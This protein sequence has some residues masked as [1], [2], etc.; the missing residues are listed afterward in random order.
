M[1][2]ELYLS[3]LRATFFM[4]NIL[5]VF[6]FC[7]GYLQSALAQ[8]DTVFWFAAPHTWV[9]TAQN[10]HIPVQ[11]IVSNPNATAASVTVTMPANAGFMPII[12]TVPAGGV[13][14]VNL[15]PFNAQI[16]HDVPNTVLNRG[17]KVSSSLPVQVTYEVVSG[18]CE[19]NPEIFTLKGNSGLGQLFYIPFQQSWPNDNLYAPQPVAS[20]D[21]VA[22]EDSTLVD[23][24]PTTAL[25]GRAAGVTFQVLLNRGQSYSATAATH[26]AGQRPSGSRVTSN[27][28]ISITVKDDLVR[29][30]GGFCADLTGD[31]LVPVTGYSKEFVLIRG[32]LNIPDVIVIIPSVTGVPVLANG[33]SLGLSVAGVPIYTS[34]TSPTTYISSAEPIL[35]SHFSGFTCEIGNAIVPG[36]SCIN[37]TEFQIPRRNMRTFRLHIVVAAG[38]QA[39]FRFNNLVGLFSTVSWLPV[40]GTGNAYYYADISLNTTQLPPLQVAKISNVSH[41][42]VIGV[43]H[44]FYTEGTRYAF[45][46]N[47]SQIQ[48]ISIVS[49]KPDG[50]FCIGDTAIL[51]TNS[52]DT[53]LW[54]RPNGLQ[55]STSQ[56]MI[57]SFNLVDTGWY[58]INSNIGCGPQIDSIYLSLISPGQV[59]ISLLGNDTIC[60]GDSVQLLLSRSGALQQVEFADA[61]G[62]FSVV[63][64]NSIPLFNSGNYY[65]RWVDSCGVRDS[66]AVVRIVVIDPQDPDIQLSGISICD[67][68]SIRLVIR[69]YSPVGTYYLSNPSGSVIVLTDSVRFLIASGGYSLV[70]VV[71]NCSSSVVSFTINGGVANFGNIIVLP[72]SILCEGDSVTL[73]I[74]QS[75][76]GYQWFLNGTIIPGGTDS[77]LKSAGRGLFEI[78]IRIQNPCVDTI[79]RLTKLVINREIEAAFVA[80]PR[81]GA[82][83]LR[84]SFTNNSSGA[85]AYEWLIND[86]VFSTQRDFSFQFDLPGFYHIRLLAF[87]SV[88]GCFDSTSLQIQV[89]DTLLIFIPNAFTPNGD[90][91]NERFRVYGEGFTDGFLAIY[92]R[93]GQLVFESSNWEEGWDGTING[94]PAESGVYVY[95]F[96]YIPS[97]GE[98]GIRSGMLKLVK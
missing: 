83:P 23:I 53:V 85:N 6:L 54:T 25:V 41:P 64:T 13:S 21:I 19:C 65:V 15:T 37:G 14:F 57:S 81:K 42:F 29:P 90:G 72:D 16:I 1:F 11:F 79:L 43:L 45:Y 18:F 51:T 70:Y 95:L 89:L 27:K 78:E 88:S 20:F 87:D 71:G 36:L 49:N 34:S 58:F 97:V 32:A 5:F 74:P 38:G 62:N 8:I 60:L 52:N 93:W 7:F 47:F 55:Q 80:S 12:T 35:V 46:S 26:L 84:V 66:T 63:L 28:P 30:Q 17:L 92:N 76:M 69:N 4:K 33:I 82:R 39:G 56:L 9:N 24:L 96:E 75:A 40:P 67:D 2:F 94:A 59:S 3:R 50:R 77:I 44:G 48:P 73:F 98:R 22:T 61:N 91:T 10:F 86:S 31:Q 68:D